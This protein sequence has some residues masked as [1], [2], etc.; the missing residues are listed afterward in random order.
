MCSPGF[1]P[2]GRKWRGRKPPSWGRGEG[3]CRAGARD[4]EEH[5][6]VSLT[7]DRRGPRGLL[8]GRAEG[9]CSRGWRRRAT[10]EVAENRGESGGQPEGQRGAAGSRVSRCRTERV[11]TRVIEGQCGGA[12]GQYRKVEDAVT[13]ETARGGRPCSVGRIGEASLHTPLPLAWGCKARLNL[14]RLPQTCPPSPPAALLA[15]LV[16]LSDFCCSPCL[17]APG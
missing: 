10:H 14:G 12:R 5:P 3:A 2:R 6:E 16:Y 4:G 17:L 15:F 11:A 9:S 13:G 1:Q 7:R 8:C